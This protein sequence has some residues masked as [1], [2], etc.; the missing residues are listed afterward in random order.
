MLHGL[1]EKHARYRVHAHDMFKA[2]DEHDIGLAN[3]IDKKLADPL[4][5]EIEDK[6]QLDGK[7]T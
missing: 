5:A 2:V 1:L 4:F 6:M 7:T 3:E